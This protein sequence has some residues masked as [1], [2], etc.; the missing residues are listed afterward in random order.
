MFPVRKTL[1]DFELVELFKSGLQHEFDWNTLDA[2][3]WNYYIEE[4][5]VSI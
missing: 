5:G 4:A 1:S 2:E 3:D